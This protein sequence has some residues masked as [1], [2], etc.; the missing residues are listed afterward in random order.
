[1]SD[2]GHLEAADIA[3]RELRLFL[4]M[5][6]HAGM[7]A[8]RQHR[9]LLVSQDEWHRWLGVLKDAPL[10]SRPA[11]SLLLRRLGYVTSR[12]ERA[13]GCQ[14]TLTSAQIGGGTAGPA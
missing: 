4:D 11:L 3:R 6:A 13:P 8:D 1:M 5:A 12:L 2:F 9:P 7:E 14:S 10:P